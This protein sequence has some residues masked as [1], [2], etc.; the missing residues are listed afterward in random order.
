M[1]YNSHHLKAC[2]Q[3]SISRPP[4]SPWFNCP[5]HWRIWLQHS[6]HP[7]DQA[8]AMQER[9]DREG[10]SRESGSWEVRGSKSVKGGHKGASQEFGGQEGARVP[11]VQLVLQVSLVKNLILLLWN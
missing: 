1:T 6:V 10:S 4:A 7:I 2:A 3:G 11:R 5:V 9:G 8:G